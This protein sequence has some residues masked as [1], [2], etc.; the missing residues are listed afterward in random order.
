MKT[1][2]TFTPRI[3][4][5]TDSSYERGADCDC[6]CSNVSIHKMNQDMLTTLVRQVRAGKIKT[7]SLNQENILMI[8]L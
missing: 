6:A 7:I 5:D 1:T 8:I 3:W 4:F 2:D